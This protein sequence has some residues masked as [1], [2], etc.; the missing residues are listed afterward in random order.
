MPDSQWL[1]RG[2]YRSPDSVLALRAYQQDKKTGT[3]RGARE[4]CST[5]SDAG[6]I[7]LL[8]RV[9]GAEDPRALVLP[10]EA[11]RTQRLQSVSRIRTVVHPGITEV[12]LGALGEGIRILHHIQ[13]RGSAASTV[14]THE[15][16][17]GAHEVAAGVAGMGPTRANAIR[18][19]EI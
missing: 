3:S 7:T 15:L 4:H 16:A 19:A 9:L 12:Q 13:V 18:T 17:D 5:G 6:R 2:S 8:E 14:V 1:A 10:C 11:R